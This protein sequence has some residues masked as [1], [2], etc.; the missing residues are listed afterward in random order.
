[1]AIEPALYRAPLGLDAINDEPT[2]IE[3]E[4]ENPDAVS[5]SMDGVEITFEP[6][7]E[8]PDDHDANLAEYMDER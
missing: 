3:V 6:E 1:M 8:H 7:R 2:E 5:I 4:I